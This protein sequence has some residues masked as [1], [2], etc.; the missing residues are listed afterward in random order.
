MIGALSLVFEVW[1][2]FESRHRKRSSL[3]ASSDPPESATLLY[4]NFIKSDIKLNGKNCKSRKEWRNGKGEGIGTHI[5]RPLSRCVAVRNHRRRTYRCIHVSRLLLSRRDE[6]HSG[7]EI[8]TQHY[9]S[10]SDIARLLKVTRATASVYKL[11][12]PDATIG[13]TRGWKETTIKRWAARRPR[14]PIKI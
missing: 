14:K 7:D 3:R 11:P 5:G 1:A 12:E 10:I 2:Y 4:Q 9:L 8:V 6:N 13:R